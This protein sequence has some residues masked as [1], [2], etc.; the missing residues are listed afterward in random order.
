MIDE[1]DP[2]RNRLNFNQNLGR[3]KFRS[4]L[5]LVLER[6]LLSVLERYG[7]SCVR[8]TGGTHLIV[9]RRVHRP[10][11]TQHEVSRSTKCGKSC[12]PDLVT[13]TKL[14][15]Q[16]IRPSYQT[17]V[18]RSPVWVLTYDPTLLPL[19]RYTAAGARARR[20]P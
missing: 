17:L 1:A 7:Y 10:V 15:D 11:P 6:Y 13:V 2:D 20:N 9:T 14:S 4:I 5:N 16:V 8:S 18:R 19:Y 12:A 3:T